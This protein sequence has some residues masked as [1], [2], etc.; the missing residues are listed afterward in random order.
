MKQLELTAGWCVQ[1]TQFL[2]VAADSGQPIQ[3]NYSYA[4]FF[5]DWIATLMPTWTGKNW[6]TMQFARGSQRPNKNL[7]LLMPWVIICCTLG[8]YCS[9]NGNGVPSCENEW[10]FL[11]NQKPAWIGSEKK[12]SASLQVHWQKNWIQLPVWRWNVPRKWQSG[13]AGSEC[14]GVYTS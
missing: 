4:L 2:V 10:E 13:R 1:A 6:E 5:S 9:T 8:Q 3:I 14:I 7:T 11:T 12:S